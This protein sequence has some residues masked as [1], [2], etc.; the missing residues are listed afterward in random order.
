MVVR[1]ERQCEGEKEREGEEEEA[2]KRKERRRAQ[3]LGSRAKDAVVSKRCSGLSLSLSHS[4]SS[5][6]IR[7]IF[8]CSLLLRSPFLLVAAALL[9]FT[10]FSSRDSLSLSL[11]VS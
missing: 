4:C 1:D 11:P 5:S 9:S 6:S 3:A 8:S 2:M 7:H 10:L